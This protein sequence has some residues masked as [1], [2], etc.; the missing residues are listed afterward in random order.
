MRRTLLTLSIAGLLVA[1]LTSA[2]GATPPVAGAPAPH[3]AA[4]AARAAFQAQPVDWHRCT[5]S[6]LRKAHV[7]CG[8]LTVPL[9]PAN[10]TGPTIQVGV[11]RKLASRG[12]YRGAIFTNPGGPGGSGLGLATLG[13]YVPD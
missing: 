8:L 12:T 5:D 13:K 9:D 10:P 6:D 3:R 1:G 7:K 11:S 4:T 2:V